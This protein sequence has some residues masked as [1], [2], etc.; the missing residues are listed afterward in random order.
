MSQFIEHITTEGERWDLLAFRYYA[1][2][3]QMGMLIEHNPHIP[4]TPV[5]PSGLRVRIPLIAQPVST[6][7]LPPWRR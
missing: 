5:F 7:E 2:V 6:Q 1:D 4:I 3:Q